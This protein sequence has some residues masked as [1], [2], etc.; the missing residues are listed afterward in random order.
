M[1]AAIK[2]DWASQGSA[3]RASAS[4]FSSMLLAKL[5]WNAEQPGG[6]GRDIDLILVGMEVSLWVA[7]QFVSDICRALPRLAATALS[8][9]K[10]LQLIGDSSASASVTGFPLTNSGFA[11]AARNAIVLVVSQ[12]GQ[13]FPVLHSARLLRNALGDR[14]FVLT[15]EVD[16][17]LGLVVGQDMARPDDFCCRI[18]ANLSGQRPAEASSVAVVAAH[19]TLTELLLFTL[20]AFDTGLPAGAR[21]GLLGMAVQAEDVAC[22]ADLRD[23]STARTLPEIVFRADG[24][25]VVGLTFAQAARRA[26]GSSWTDGKLAGVHEGL[27]AQGQTW[28]HR[29]TET[30][31]ATVLST[32]YVSATILL[33]FAP[34]NVVS[35]VVN[36]GDHFWLQCPQSGAKCAIGFALRFMDV[37]IYV[38]F[39]YG[40]ILLSR[41]MRGAP[42]LA[43]RGKRALLIADVPWVH[44][45][46]ENFLSKLF[47]LSYGDNSL[48]VHGC[49]PQDSAAHRFTHRVVRGSLMVL[50]RPDGRVAALARKEAACLHAAMQGAAIQ[51]LGVG[52]ETVS[53]GHNTRLGS[54]MAIRNHLVLPTCRRPYVS[55]YLK[56]LAGADPLA[57][58]EQ[59]SSGMVVSPEAAALI[60]FNNGLLLCSRCETA[61][62]RRSCAQCATQFCFVCNAEVH[63]AAAPDG[64]ARRLHATLPLAAV[65]RMR[66]KGRQAV[67]RLRFRRAKME[68]MGNAA[69]AAADVSASELSG[70]PLLTAFADHLASGAILAAA[71]SK[72]VAIG[73]PL[74]M[75]HAT[76]LLAEVR[77]SRARAR[78]QKACRAVLAQ[79]SAWNA[80]L[81]R[82][83]ASEESRAATMAGSAAQ[84]HPLLAHVLGAEAVLVDLAEGRFSS[85]ERCVACMVMFHAMA[86]RVSTSSWPLPAWRISRSQSILRVASGSCPVSGAE[87]VH[88]LKARKQ[89]TAEF[90][91]ASFQAF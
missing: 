72:L 25:S 56:T 30:W 26:I 89:A 22:L 76:P 16:T 4:A 86:L 28:A 63:S 73:V 48:D 83:R 57:A 18:F 87:T 20:H 45:V 29:I 33:Q 61:P 31:H 53:V 74:G 40:T 27:V 49:N 44:Q 2:E 17:K 1:L 24:E 91:A 47:A 13:T 42:V 67:E 15:A 59:L 3:N 36:A 14:V 37:C 80:L 90:K 78:W 64:Q 54:V 19:A 88:L 71:P 85:L 82:L 77:S 65:L 55:E 60:S 12:S 70:A 58:L 41:K 52:C 8:A 81:E 5:A 32:I 50:G 9:N 68:S 7:E 75:H 6:G 79:R 66:L 10:V 11:R 35:A 43:R 34:M 62:A 51:N 84:A 46:L 39:I 69:A 38:G 21:E 23:S